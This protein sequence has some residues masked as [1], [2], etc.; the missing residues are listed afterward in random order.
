MD[1]LNYG[2]IGNC[3]TAALI[4]DKGSIDWLC[5]PNFDSPSIFASLLDREKGGY[6]GFEVSPDYQISQSYVPHTNI[7]S[8]NFV[9]EENEFAVVDFMPC[10]HLSDASNC[11]RPAEIYRYIRRIKGTPRF[12]INYEPA[13]DYARGKTIFNTTSEYIETYSTSNSKDRQYLYSSLPLHKIL[14]RE[15][16]EYCRTLVYWLNWTDR[17]KK[18]TVYNDVIE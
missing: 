7:L 14:E 2:V 16:L 6:F 3:C 8:T 18:F 4:S 1:K 11:Y 13:P 12:K 9:S 5:F 10:Y 17:T 15:K